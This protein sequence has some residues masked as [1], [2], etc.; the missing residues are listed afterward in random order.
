[1]PIEDFRAAIRQE[2]V[3]RGL[4]LNDGAHRGYVAAQ[5]RCG[6]GEILGS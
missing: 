4:D 6:T 2:T 3:S 1:V 5:A